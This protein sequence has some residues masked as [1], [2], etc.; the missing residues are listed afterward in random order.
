MQ[1]Q[2]QAREHDKFIVRMPDGMRGRI[3]EAAKRNH[4]SMNNEIVHHLAQAFGD[5]ERPTTGGEFGDTTPAAGSHDSARQGA[6][7]VHG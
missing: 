1:R 5:G 4:R 6:P 3:A 7:A 2:A